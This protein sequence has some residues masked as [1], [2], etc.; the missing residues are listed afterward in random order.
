MTT[1]LTRRI[2]LFGDLIESG[3]FRDR[4]PVKHSDANALEFSPLTL[5]ELNERTADANSWIAHTY[6]GARRNRRTL[7]D[8]DT[9]RMDAFS[10]VA[11]MYADAAWQRAQALIA[12]QAGEPTC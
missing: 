4:I 1:E 6:R 11:D 8:F 10:D 2:A 3:V 5:T 7:D 12:P 9:D